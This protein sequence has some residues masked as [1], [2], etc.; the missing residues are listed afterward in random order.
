MATM[1]DARQGSRGRENHNLTNNRSG[2][3]HSLHNSTSMPAA[4]GSTEIRVQ[5][6]EDNRRRNPS[7]NEE[8]LPE[9]LQKGLENFSESLI[10]V[11]NDVTALEVNTMIVS[12]ITGTKFIP[13]EAYQNIFFCLTR[14]SQIPNDKKL[15][16]N[17]KDELDQVYQ[18][19]RLESLENEVD[20]RIPPQFTSRGQGNIEH[21]NTSSKAAGRYWK[22]REKLV[23]EYI[24]IFFKQI[25]EDDK[26]PANLPFPYDI[27][28]EGY[29]RTLY[30]S[31]ELRTIL[32]NSRFLRSLRKINE[33]KAAV[34][35]DDIIYAQTVL[36]LDGDIIN[37]Y[38]KDLFKNPDKELIIKIHHEGVTGGEK[39]WRG[40]LQFTVNLVKSI[41]T[42]LRN[43]YK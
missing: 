40:L 42:P 32:D 2:I 4:S 18:L 12:E 27:N 16:K 39:Q 38:R 36:Q 9:R 3:V 34:D 30:F 35:N 29:P 24:Q 28:I 17:L 11:L 13:E 15:H 8:N 6:H 26:L 10:E 25:Y 37:R 1:A 14:D 7:Q 33:L 41:A 20:S 22:L 5:N 31:K 19:D 23:R 43:G 21:T